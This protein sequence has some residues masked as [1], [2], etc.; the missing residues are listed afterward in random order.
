[1]EEPVYRPWV[2]N[3]AGRIHDPVHRLRFLKSAA[4]QPAGP[5]RGCRG[6][7]AWAVRN[8]KLQFVL[9]AL[10]AAVALGLVGLVT[11]S[12]S[13]TALPAA[14]LPVQPAS[15]ITPPEIWLVEAD[16]IE[17][18][19][20]NGLRIDNRYSESYHPRSYLAYP[21]DRVSRPVRRRDPAGIVFH[22][23][24][25]HLAPFESGKNRELRQIGES[26]LEYVKRMCAYHFVIDRFG[27][28]F[29]VVAENDSADHAGPSV[30]ADGQWLYL[31]LNSSFLGV[32]FETHT[33]PGQTESGA[34]PAQL[35]SAA[36]LIELLR[37]RYRI[38]AGNCV[39]HAQ[40]SVNPAN[41]E[42]GYHTDWA[43]SFPF[44]QIGLPDNYAQALPAVWA[45]GFLATSGFRATAGVRMAEGID[46][47]EEALRAAAASDKSSP[48][49][50]RKRLQAWYRDRSR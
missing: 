10:A 30:W 4:Q 16:G 37:S 27:R 38:P 7:L 44:G 19:Y 2:E 15:G 34:S 8:P 18:T 20:S 42:A 22:S 26:L 29:R 1:M 36:M 3:V 13:A 21:A 48:T 31:N 17:E 39:T 41:F 23:T 5:K 24:E 14:R 25:S 11:T 12:G 45:F 50:Y 47:A 46:I 9:L 32:A 40:V 28:V 43:S 6:F 49:A 33:D 35:R